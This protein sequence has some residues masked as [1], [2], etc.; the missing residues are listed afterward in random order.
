MLYRAFLDIRSMWSP[1]RAHQA[2]CLADAVHNLPHLLHA[3]YF[4]WEQVEGPLRH[5]Q[6]TFYGSDETRGSDYLR[7]IAQVKNG[8]PV[9]P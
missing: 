4:T 2:S 5:Y 3:D 8:E 7:M 1:E 6:Q 9:S